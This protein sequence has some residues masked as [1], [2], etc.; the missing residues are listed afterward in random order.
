[1]IGQDSPR[2]RAIASSPAAALFARKGEAAPVGGR[3]APR[4]VITMRPLIAAD[5]APIALPQPANT[6]LPLPTLALP[7]MQAPPMTSGAVMP[8][9]APTMGPQVGVAR[10]YSAPRG[11]RIVG[12]TEIRSPVRGTERRP[13]TATKR[14]TLRLD[15]AMRARLARFSASETLSVQALLT[16]ALQRHLPAISVERTAATSPRLP[17]DAS[18]AASVCRRSVRFDAHLYWRLKTAAANRRRSMQSIMVAAL[19]GYL[20]ELEAGGWTGLPVERQTAHLTVV[21]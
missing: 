11:D 9:V 19:D 6:T 17:R 14:T 8:A 1:M 5:E 10:M 12:T 7:G 15:R 16:R 2:H 21:A 20:G 3:R 4:R 13:R 18:T